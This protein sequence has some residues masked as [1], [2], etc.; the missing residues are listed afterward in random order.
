MKLRLLPALAGIALLLAGVSSPQPAA[1]ALWKNLAPGI[2]YRE[3][4]LPGP[5]HVYVTRLDRREPRAALE[6]SLGQGRISAGA[7]T[8]R[9]QAERYDQALNAWGG[10]W[11]ARNQVIAAINGSYFDTVTGVPWSGQIQ[12]G[13]Y[14]RRFSDRQNSSGFVW[15]LDRRAFVGTCVQQRPAK[16]TISL[17]G[18]GA[19]KFDGLNTP[20]GKDELVIFTPQYDAASP[21]LEKGTPG[22]D[23]LVSLPTPLWIMP[24]PEAVR[25]VVRAVYDGQGGTSLPFDHIVLAAR[26]K[27]YQALKG[28]IKVGDTVSIS[29]ELR[30][31]T[32]DCQ[33]PRPESWTKAYASVSGGYIFL[34]NGVIQPQGDLGAILQNPRTAIALNERYVFFVVVDG[35][36]RLRSL[37]MSMIDLAT[38][39]QMR[40]GAA[41][42]IAQDGGGS[43]TLVVKGQVM[44]HPNADLPDQA[45]VNAPPPTAGPAGKPPV[46]E[47]AVANGMLMVVVQ[48]A[49]FSRRFQAGQSLR[50]AEGPVN[51][52]LG[53]GTN[54]AVI[55]A[56]PSD[57]PAVVQ[58]HALNGV[59][60]KGY[61]WWQ[62][63]I[64]GQTGW[65]GEEFLIS[66]L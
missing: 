65:V 33:Q 4:F 13:W 10:E 5:N 30:H 19:I 64:E 43:S 16:Q 60:A 20:P 12:S 56:Y 11:G 58:E 41:W 66:D 27:A 9:Q 49:E 48:P 24:E 53:P 36:D 39:A 25:G 42:G 51:L 62:V 28:K 1:A 38:F 61:Y 40:L 15:T 46:I 44:N 22:M 21:L 26:G 32:S 23:V 3:F 35:R 2:D 37:G 17:A 47:R 50:L 54:Y 7:E 6:S 52:R 45:P 8:V 57:S 29:Q 55:N 59:L 63:E 14:A 34:M 18:Q 31:L